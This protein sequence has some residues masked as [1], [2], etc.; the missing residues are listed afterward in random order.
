MLNTSNPLNVSTSD[1]A[2]LRRQAR[3]RVDMK[4][5]FLTHLLVFSCVNAGLFLLGGAERL[6]G[7]PLWGWGLGLA[8]HGLVTW[9]NLQ[10]G[11]LRERMLAAELQT[12]RERA[13]R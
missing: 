13:G 11:D 2:A 5:G 9:L 3:K 6:H 12:L 1:E 4:M 8:I 10:G 7:A